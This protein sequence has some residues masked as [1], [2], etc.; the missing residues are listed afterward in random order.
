MRILKKPLARFDLIEQADYFEQASGIE[1]AEQFLV[2]AEKTFHQLAL[3]P[4][5]GSPCPCHN[6]SLSDLRQWR[7][8]GFEKH[9]I[10]YLPLPDGIDVLRM[11]HSS[12]D[13]EAILEDE[14]G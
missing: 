1:K 14:E 10:F 13:I 3:M 2:A 4:L 6:P 12:Q 8:K 9:L 11:L 5:M 7:I